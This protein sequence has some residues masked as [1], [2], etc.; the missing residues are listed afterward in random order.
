MTMLPDDD[1]LTQTEDWRDPAH[2]PGFDPRCP[3][4]WRQGYACPRGARAPETEHPM[5]TQD[6]GEHP[7]A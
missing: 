7:C 1:R 2:W 5:T 6:E 4:C 3:V